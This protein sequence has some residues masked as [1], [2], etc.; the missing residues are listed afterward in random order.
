MKEKNLMNPETLTE[1]QQRLEQ[2]D[3]ILVTSHIRPD[4][5]AVGSMLGL[6][7]ALQGQGKK[8]TS[9]PLPSRKSEDH[10]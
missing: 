5:D 3:N 7:L 9:T 6:G 2:S 8:Q 10:Q 4:G 1:I